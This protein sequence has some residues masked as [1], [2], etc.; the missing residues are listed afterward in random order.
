MDAKLVAAPRA[1]KYYGGKGGA[2]AQ[3]IASLLP[4][5]SD[6]FYVEPFS[7]MASVLLARQPVRAEMLNDL[8][9]R[10]VNWWRVVR[11][12]PEEFARLVDYTPNSH[13]EFVASLANMDDESLPPIRRALAF[14]VV[15]SQSMNSGDNVTQGAWR[16]VFN[17]TAGAHTWGRERMGALAQRLA[18]VQL[19]CRDAI[20][21]LERTSKEAGAV[22]YCDPP[23]HT[24][25]THAYTHAGV[26]DGLAEGLQAQ[27]GH[28][29]LSGYR[30]EWDSLGWQRHEFA[31]FTV[32][33]S[34]H[35]NARRRTEVLWTNYQ[36]ANRL[37]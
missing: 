12:Q 28:V 6:D 26:P 5:S 18:R 20:E 9:G 17:G 32:P 19:E 23:Y 24:A 15:V 14:H 4:W 10:V 7:G 25:Y 36:P 21:V 1:L 35:G 11:D 37:L 31:T 29:A 8:N 30:D 27:K 33:A 3:W 34:D 16:R 22:V 13:A 2:K